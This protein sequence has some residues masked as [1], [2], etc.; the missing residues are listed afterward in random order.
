M[1]RCT[2]GIQPVSE[3]GSLLVLSRSLGSDSFFFYIYFLF[4]FI[5]VGFV[6]H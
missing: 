1:D 3:V 4:F 5:V 6:I 2:G